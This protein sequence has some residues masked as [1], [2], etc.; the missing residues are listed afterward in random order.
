MQILH[1]SHSSRCFSNRH[2]AHGNPTSVAAGSGGTSRTGRAAA[3]AAAAGAAAKE[4]VAA[5][6]GAAAKG[7]AAAAAGAA[8]GT[9]STRSTSS[10][11]RRTNGAASMSGSQLQWNHP[12]LALTA[13]GKGSGEQ[14]AGAGRLRQAAT[15]AAETVRGVA[16][17]GGTGRQTSGLVGVA[18]SA[19][20]GKQNAAG[21]VSTAAAATT[22]IEGN[23]V[24]ETGTDARIGIGSVGPGASTAETGIGGELKLS[25][26]VRHISCCLCVGFGLDHRLV[27]AS[28]ALS[29]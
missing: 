24:G 20:G 25:V 9:T 14:T 5:A 10:S 23:T 19:T 28:T 8:A 2:S 15:A 4:R 7:G 13:G 18:A 1:S 21:M 11:T 17:A 6:A 27:L 22:M 16:G 26:R 3:N 29:C 12:G